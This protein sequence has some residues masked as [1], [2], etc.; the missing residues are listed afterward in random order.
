MTKRQSVVRQHNAGTMTEAEFRS[1]ILSAL[2]N[3]S[4]FWKPKMACIRKAKV[5]YNSYKCSLCWQVWP[6]KLPPLP[7]KKRKRQNIV[8]DHIL[9]VV[10]PDTGFTSYDNWIERC[11]VEEEGFQALCY[12]CNYEKT[13]ENQKL[14]R[15]N[16]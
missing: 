10:N 8:A 5:A 4:R 13:Q 9:E 2:R 1:F 3:A 11:F 7:W 16:K 6:S 14:R 12:K 15:L